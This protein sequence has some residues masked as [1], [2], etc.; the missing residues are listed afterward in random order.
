MHEIKVIKTYQALGLLTSWPWPPPDAGVEAV[1]RRAVECE[2]VHHAL[3]E[4][5]R[6]EPG[7]WHQELH[8]IE[9]RCSSEI[10]QKPLTVASLISK[11][12]CRIPKKQRLDH[13]KKHVINP[14][15][16]IR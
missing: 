14:N 10:L 15:M 13:V 11:K 5:A 2:G 8:K 1:P 3:A 4:G 16:N 6:W 9:E 12:K 7:A